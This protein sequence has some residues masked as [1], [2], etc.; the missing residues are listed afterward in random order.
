MNEQKT[1][2][3]INSFWQ[4]D[5]TFKMIPISTDCPFAEVI[6]IIKGKGLAVISKIEYEKFS[7][8][9]RLNSKGDRIPIKKG[10]QG[11]MEFEQDR[12]LFRTLYEYQIIDRSEVEWFIK[13]FAENEELF[14]YQKFL[15]FEPPQQEAQPTIGTV[16]TVPPDGKQEA[17]LKKVTE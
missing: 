6:Y 3:L 13:K 15:N 12:K 1:M 5:V 7:L 17:T 9:P 10:K 2:M 4:G 8:V 16:G 14:D 11:E